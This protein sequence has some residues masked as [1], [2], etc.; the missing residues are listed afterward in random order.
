MTAWDDYFRAV[1]AML[2]QHP[3]QR[4]GQAYYNTLATLH[5]ELAN[6]VHGTDA[7]PFD[8]T[9]RLPAFLAVVRPALDAMS[10]SEPTD[11]Q[12]AADAQYG[13]PRNP[14]LGDP[15][16]DPPFTV[17]RHPDDDPRDR[18][19]RRAIRLATSEAWA[20]VTGAPPVFL[21]YPVVL[22]EEVASWPVE[23]FSRYAPV[24][25][26]ASADTAREKGLHERV[27]VTS[28][29]PVTVTPPTGRA[30]LDD[31]DIEVVGKLAWGAPLDGS[32]TEGDTPFR[33]PRPEG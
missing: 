26:L 3:E 30:A 14:Y 1:S 29:G 32:D 4:T 2:A 5:P 12:A 20:L 6:Q 31:S 21:G 15:A 22:P 33:D 8:V 23:H 13:S 10:T 25:R 17:R 9:D 27:E 18:H 28:V 16:L 24:F 19:A 7:D 11:P